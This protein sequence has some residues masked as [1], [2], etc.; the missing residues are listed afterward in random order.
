MKEDI[1]SCFRPGG[2]AWR[3]YSGV[4]ILFLLKFSLVNPKSHIPDNN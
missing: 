4:L 3:N 1:L 2:G